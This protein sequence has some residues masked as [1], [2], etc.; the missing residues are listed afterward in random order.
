MKNLVTYTRQGLHG[1]VRYEARD[2]AAY[3][4][5]TRRSQGFYITDCRGLETVVSAD[6]L[7]DS[8]GR[9][10]WQDAVTDQNARPHFDKTR[11]Q[12]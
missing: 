3:S 12:T 9:R 2:D 1:N 11:V 4:V 5:P 10:D 7:L 6:A 8:N